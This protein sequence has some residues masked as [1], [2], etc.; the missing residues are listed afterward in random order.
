[1]NNRR[2]DNE[3]NRG[4]Y[5]GG[6]EWRNRNVNHLGD[7]GRGGY[8]SHGG[9]DQ[10]RGGYDQGYGNNRGGNDQNRS[11]YGSGDQWQNRSGGGD[12]RSREGRRSEN[13]RG[14][15]D[16][17]GDKLERAGEWAE[18]RMER[19]GDR[20]KGW[21]DDDDNRGR[22]D[23]SY[24]DRRSDRYDDNRDRDSY[25]TTRGEYD[26]DRSFGRR[27]LDGAGYQD[28]RRYEDEDR[29]NRGYSSSGSSYNSRRSDN[30]RGFFDRAEDKLERAGDRVKSWFDDDDDRRGKGSYRD[31]DDSYS[32]NYNRRS[33]RD[34]R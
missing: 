18:N 17:A 33:N 27:Y 6:E 13:D 31:H 14:F 12:N 2:F 29:G 26:S 23:R 19:A 20:V 22:S 8:Q 16:R 24:S 11:S 10:N 5:R 1:M 34:W 4:E 7:Q 25:R 30:D 15:F 28:A 3:N 32:D 9:H 21:F